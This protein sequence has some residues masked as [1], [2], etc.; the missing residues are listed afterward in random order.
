MRGISFHLDDAEEKR[1]DKITLTSREIFMLGMEAAEVA[2]GRETKA[3]LKSAE[4]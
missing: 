1:R 2:G 4:E 3:D